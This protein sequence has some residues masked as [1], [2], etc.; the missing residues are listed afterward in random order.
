M[1]KKVEVLCLLIMFSLAITA[2]GR[3]EEPEEELHDLKGNVIHLSDYHGKWLIVNYWASWCKPC[4]LEIPEL[5]AFNKVHQD[6]D[7]VIVGFSY[8]MA[9]PEKLPSIVKHMQIQ[10]IT[11]QEDPASI[12]GIEDI[13]ALPATFIIS[14]KGKLVKTLLGP[15]TKV[16]LEKEIVS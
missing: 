7:A 11:L 6:K 3:S 16:S 1:F 14:P 15:Q 12:V 8:D 5:N 13:P 4:Y 2:C 9:K 10:F